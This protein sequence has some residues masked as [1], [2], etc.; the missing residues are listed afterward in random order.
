MGTFYNYDISANILPEVFSIE[1]W[2]I[3]D[4]TDVK[5]AVSL[6]ADGPMSIS[7]KFKNLCRVF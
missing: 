1:M 3:Y 4:E 5:K 6:G 2:D 7:G